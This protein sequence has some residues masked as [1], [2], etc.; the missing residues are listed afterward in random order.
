MFKAD[1]ASAGAICL[2]LFLS[3]IAGMA[4][5]NGSSEPEISVQEIVV[6]AQR[7][8]EGIQT[9]PIAVAVV[10]PAQ[11]ERGM[12]TS[13]RD[14]SAIVPGISMTGTSS[15]ISPAIRGIHSD[16]TDPGNDP[17]VA[18]YVD[19][20]Y[21]INQL[22]NNMDLPDVSRIE[23]LKGPQGTLFGRN[24]TGGAIQ[25]FTLE[26][27]MTSP[28]VHLD[29][30]F[31]RF[32]DFLAKGFLS[33]PIVQDKLAISGS[34]FFEQSD[35]YSRDV[36]KNK[37]TSGLDSRV[38]RL[39]LL[40]T[41][42][43]G[44]SIEV[45]GV[46]ADRRDGETSTYTALNGNSIARNYAY[47]GAIIPEQPYQFAET[48]EPILK[49][50]SYSAGARIT[51]DSP[52]GAFSSVFAYTNVKAFYTNDADLTALD[53][54]GYP[55]T[56]RQ[57]G[58]SEELLFNSKPFGPFMVTGGAFYYD[59]TGRYDP[60][61]L[62]GVLLTGSPGPAGQLYGFMVQ[63]T[64]AY[65]GFGELTV[66]PTDPLTLIAGVRY[67]WEMRRAAGG[68]F[69]SP[70]RPDPLPPLGPGRKS[71]G[72]VTPRASVRYTLPSN[73]N[74]Y[75]TFS[76]GFKSGGF[77][78]SALQPQPFKPEKLT[79][80]EMGLKT[81]PSRPVNANLSV[82]YYDYSD[83]QVSASV[84]GF[85]ITTNAASSRITGADADI[86]AKISRN[87]SVTVGLSYLNAKYRQFLGAPANVPTGGPTC[88]CGNTT[89]IVDLSGGTLPFSPKFSG[90][91][92]VNY[93]TVLNSGK[94]GLSAYG[95]YTDR[96]N[97][98]AY[99]RIH[100]KSYATLAL[101]ASFQ[102]A[103]SHLDFYAWGK[104][105]ANERYF[106]NVFITN[107]GDGVHYAPPTTYGAGVKYDF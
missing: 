71:F 2:A 76:R 18:I 98:D 42:M 68:Y 39:K 41:P 4:Q 48:F 89:Q 69:A 63:K 43:E 38:A 55:I 70:D 82:F 65:A 91:L 27:S 24:A 88:R 66:T 106:S 92:G 75:F 13:T 12:V 20:V 58:A 83:Q 50:T 72:S 16:Q 29:A 59:S 35:G 15:N 8:P 64:K 60:L 34:V 80:Y 107:D 30:S 57:E 47:A 81:N 26:P 33:A 101:R 73:D 40:A 45:F 19:G 6:T 97:Y 84:N 51:V 54:V 9:V 95:F 105:V 46:Y 100:Q 14:L 11:L 74:I 21:Q 5:T 32:N 49:A 10:T 53:L 36:V 28:T 17:N 90:S 61:A 31:G 87:W 99:P 25:I 7:R 22:A 103:E 104:N 78:I 96:F 52:I 23:V 94:L 1:M 44:L 85:N 56:E 79:A 62:Q 102:P 37:R 67:S 3:P 93:E 77:N 86:V